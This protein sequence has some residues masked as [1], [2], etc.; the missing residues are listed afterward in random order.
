[1]L[2]KRFVHQEFGHEGEAGGVVV[3]W[4]REQEFAL[5]RRELMGVWVTSIG[6]DETTRRVEGSA[7]IGIGRAGAH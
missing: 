2:H 1:M 6:G 7:R 4:K 3:S 5:K